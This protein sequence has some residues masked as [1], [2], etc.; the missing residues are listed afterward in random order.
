R[1]RKE[2]LRTLAKELRLVVGENYKVIQQTEL[3][4]KSDNYDEPLVKGILQVIN[5]ERIA[6][7]SASLLEAENMRK[8]L[9][10]AAEKEKSSKTSVRITKITARMSALICYGCPVI[11]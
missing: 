10:L 3:I 11:N 8:A 1:P 7:E 6:K 4:S 2:D 5:K 9:V